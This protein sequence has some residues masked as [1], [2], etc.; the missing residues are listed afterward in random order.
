MGCVRPEL[1][2]DLS[3]RQVVIPVVLECGILFFSEVVE[4]KG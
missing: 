3:F 1:N 4:F 2:L